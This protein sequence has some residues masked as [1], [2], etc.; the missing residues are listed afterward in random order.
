VRD[1]PVSNRSGVE[2]EEISH[3]EAPA[4]AAASSIARET[5]ETGAHVPNVIRD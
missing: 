3:P 2:A 1:P 4:R 5:V